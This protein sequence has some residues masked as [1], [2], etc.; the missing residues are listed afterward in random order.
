MGYP[1]STIG[2]SFWNA[3]WALSS[4]GFG[5]NLIWTRQQ[6]I[7]SF[8]GQVIDHIGGILYTDPERGTF[9]LKLLRDD[10]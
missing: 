4:E 7:E 2:W 5:L 8:I 6:P 1:Q 9:E 3:A 10:Y